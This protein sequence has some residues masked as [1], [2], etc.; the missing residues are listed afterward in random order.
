MP[1]TGIGTQIMAFTITVFCIVA[2]IGV[3]AIAKSG[4]TSGSTTTTTASSVAANTQTLGCSAPGVQCTGFNISS[5]SLTVPAAAA[6]TSNLTLSIRNS[7]NTFVG[8]FEVYVTE[9]NNGIDVNVTPSTYKT[10]MQNPASNLFY[11]GT[12]AAGTTKTISFTLPSAEYTI[13]VGS[14]YTIQVIGFPAASSSSPPETGDV[15][16]TAYVTATA[17]TSIQTYGPGP[18]STFPASWDDP[19][20]YLV[21]GN[22]TTVMGSGSAS[23]WAMVN[24]SQI[25]PK[26]VNSSVFQTLGAGRTWITTQWG[27]FQGTYGDVVQGQFMFIAGGMPDP[28]AYASINYDVG[29]GN[30]TAI[31]GLL[32]SCT[33]GGVYGNY[34]H[35]VGGNQ[36]TYAVG[37][38][39]GINFTVGDS[40]LANMTITASTSC[41]GNFIVVQGGPGTNG[42]PTNGPVVYNSTKHPGCSGPPLKEVLNPGQTYSQTAEWN[43]T[44]DAGVQVQAGE[45]Q[46]IALEAGYLGQLF[47]VDLGYVIIGNQTTG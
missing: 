25:Y 32:V 35:L 22:E 38:R 47:P 4:A 15:F 24:L 30:I 34:A 3:V 16:D 5:V 27:I 36:D 43:Q 13:V 37:Q 26:I 33:Q 45:Y 44:D 10:V 23:Q 42:F 14:P 6:S 2:A 12:V 41:L 28:E 40:Y 7:G 19:C 17:T 1:K 20:G 29:S 39:V 18:I 11:N 8:Y 46:I 9:G 21:Q 31:T